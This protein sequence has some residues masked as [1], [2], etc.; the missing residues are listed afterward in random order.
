M[1]YPDLNVKQRWY[2]ILPDS[3]EVR[4]IRIKELSMYTA[5]IEITET[6]TFHAIFGIEVAPEVKR[7][8]KGDIKWIE[9]L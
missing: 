5:L 3:I 8:R 4:E 1:T 9:Q 2:A 6:E 7:Y